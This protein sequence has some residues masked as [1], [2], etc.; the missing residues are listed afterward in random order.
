MRC[1]LDCP[2]WPNPS[3]P[4]GRCTS[5]IHLARLQAILTPIAARI[6]LAGMLTGTGTVGAAVEDV[7]TV[8]SRAFWLGGRA[9]LL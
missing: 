1:S 5:R 7:E 3:L 6:C 4:W 8:F 2:D 9:S